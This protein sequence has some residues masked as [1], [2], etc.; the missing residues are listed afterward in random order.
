M[1]TAPTL[2]ERVGGSAFFERLVD[3]FYDGVAGDDVLA[4]LYPERPDF[5]GARHRLTLFLVQYWGGPDDY[6]DRARP[7]AAAH[8]PPALHDRHGPSGTA[9]WRT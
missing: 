7:P 6:S 3:T 8:A 9:G 5:T 1:T 2:Y 4:A